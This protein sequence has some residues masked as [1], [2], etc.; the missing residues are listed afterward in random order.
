M[1]AAKGNKN[2]VGNTG[3]KSLND[4]QL[5][6]SVRS[7]ALTEIQKY[8]EGK[9]KGYKNEEMKAAIILKLAPTLLPR[10][11]EHTGEDGGDINVNLTNYG[12]QLA[13]QLRPQAVSAS[14]PA[15]DGQRNEAGSGDLA[16]TR[17]QG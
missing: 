3:G 12:N 16:Q 13:V 10:L 1:A 15:S 6:A 11:N 4:R 17:G 8:L 5:A 14:A 9:E 2:A 7:L